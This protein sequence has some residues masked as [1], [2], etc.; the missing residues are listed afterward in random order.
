M[1]T[2]NHQCNNEECDMHQFEHFRKMSECNEPIP[3]PKCGQITQKLISQSSFRLK[4]AGWY[5][6]GYT[7]NNWHSEAIKAGKDPYKAN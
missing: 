7:G 1:P 5:K 4:G 3:C 6:D 2:Y